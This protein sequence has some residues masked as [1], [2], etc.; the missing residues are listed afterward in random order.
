MTASKTTTQ[1]APREPAE[2]EREIRNTQVE[3][4]RTVDQIGERLTPR[5]VIN[6]LLDEAEEK[7]IDARYLIEGARRNPLALGMITLG[8]IWLVS[9]SDARLSSLSPGFLK[10]SGSHPDDGHGSYL[11]HISRFEPLPG[12]DPAAFRRRR[13]LGRANYFMLEQR[14]DEDETS[15]R[16]RLDEATEKLRE[17][18]DSFLENAHSLGQ[19]ASHTAEGAAHKVMEAYVSH[20]IVGGMIAAL[21]GALAGAL[22][23][24]TETEEKEAGKLG[25]RALDAIKD[26]AGDL[27][28]KAHTQKD[29]FVG[30]TED[31]IRPSGREK[32]DKSGRAS[33][34]YG[35]A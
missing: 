26:E 32:G 5:N 1:S 25:S 10:G 6:A 24:L 23:P 8:G 9:D 21:A 18:R 16:D 12:E 20:P 34:G 31:K 17:R 3:M 4:G 33:N 11:E 29:R 35:A 7:G 28:E 14:H 15:F 30:E 13:D 2:I 19:A 27:A 22:A